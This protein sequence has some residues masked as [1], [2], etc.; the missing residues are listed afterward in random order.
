VSIETSIHRV[1]KMPRLRWFAWP[2]LLAAGPLVLLILK[3]VPGLERQVLHIPAVHLL[4]AGGA[5]LLGVGLAFFVLHVARRAGDGRVY[6][7]GMGFLTIASI[8]LIHGISTP[9]V[10]MAGRGL[11]TAWSAVL[12]LTLGS[13]FFALSGLEWSAKANQR[14][15]RFARAGLLLYLI[16]WLTYTWLLL[17]VLATPPADAQSPGAPAA[18]TS[19][20]DHAAHVG[21]YEE[22]E[23]G[24]YAPDPADAGITAPAALQSLISPSLSDRIDTLLALL[25]VACYGFAAVRHYHLYRRSPSAAGLAITCGIVLFGEALLTQRL[26]Q[27]YTTTFWLYHAE[28]FIGFGVIGYA[29][30]LAYRRGQS[31]IGL[32]ESLFLAPTRMRI[33]AGYAQAMDTLVDMLARGEEP[34]VAQLQDLRGQLGMTESQV[35][36][37]KRAALAVAEERRQRQELERLNAALR[38]LERDKDQL[39]QMVVHDLKNPL[40]ALIGFLEVLRMDQL[41]TGQALLLEGALSSGKNLSG[42]IGDLLDVGRMEEGRMELDRTYFPSRDLL[43]QCTAEMSAWLAQDG[44]TVHIEAPADLPPLYA[45]KRLIRRVLLNLLSNAIKHTPPGTHITLSAYSPSRPM[46]D[47]SAATSA[48]LVIEV[49]DSGPGIP[50]EYL[51]HIFEKFGR[52]SSESRGE[53]RSRQDSTGLGLTFCRLAVEA[54]GGTIG[55]TSVVGQGTTFQIRLPAAT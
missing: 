8:F 34:T 27:V 18:I 47:A 4:I 48:A 6:L 40:T 5:T 26:S 30:L 23:Y 13:V 20:Q 21:G 51:E 35:H 39:M 14:L 22:G 33:Q 44:K 15:M 1:S 45:D 42:L 38:Q 36:V 16:F 24:E 53:S 19:T 31:R 11:A 46:G 17:D 10:L 41:T 52:V 25:G 12:S 3:L 54:H 43:A 32:L 49:A 50:A 55:V 9:D 37:L 2:G 28:E 29:G 7:V